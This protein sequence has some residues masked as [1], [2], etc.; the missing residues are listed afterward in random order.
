M[1][2]KAALASSL[3]YRPRLIVLDEPFSGLDV[4]VRDQLVESILERTADSTVFLASHDLAE[5]ESFGSHIA[6]LEQG[7]LQF[8]EEMGVLSQ[9]F[10]EIEVT[11]E[12]STDW[13]REWPDR[14]L[15][16]EKSSVVIRFIDSRFDAGRSEAEVRRL[17]SGV[18]DVTARSMSLRSIFIAL[19]KAVKT[20]KSV[21]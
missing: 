3:A 19:T 4:L 20:G 8:V 14:W 7:R 15:N 21:R 16:P 17:F 5:I 9:R 2:V 10:R 12:T 18:L 13:P 11:L 1:R 6:Y